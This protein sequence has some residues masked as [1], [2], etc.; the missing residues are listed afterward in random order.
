M[1]ALAFGL[2]TFGDLAVDDNGNPI[3]YAAAI[4]QVVDEAILADAFGVDVFAV[5]EHHR[6][7]YAISSP[8]TVLAGIATLTSR[9]RLSSSVTVLPSDDPV[10]VFQRF[11]TVDALSRGRAEVM[12]GRGS[13]TE[14]YPLFG[15]DPSEKDVLF[16]EKLD[17]FVRLL[18]EKPVTWA[19]TTRPALTDAEIFPRTDSGRLT[20]WIAAGATPQSVVRAARHGLPLMLSI[21]A[22]PIQGRALQFALYRRAT[23]QLGNP[24]LPL[25]LHSPGFVADTD[26]QAREIFYPA[27]KAMRDRIGGERG[28]LPLTPAEFEQEVSG[29][30]LYVGSPE[31][32]ARRVATTIGALGVDRFDMIYSFGAQPV[33]TR[34]RSIELFGSKV[35]PMI[36]DLLA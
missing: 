9:I 29:G 20:T 22:G 36:R 2:D 1:K 34:L 11:A 32:V 26:E 21:I 8:D 10:R 23:E 28:L 35:I 25:G 33:S 4:R 18:D 6:A 13:F 16:E 19:G 12:L 30:A 27:Y 15:F 14:S 7:E 31:T 3:S 17:L 5:G 24:G